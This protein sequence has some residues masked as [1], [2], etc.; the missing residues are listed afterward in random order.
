MQGPSG[1]TRQDH[2][3]RLRSSP[4]LLAEKFYGRCFVVL[5]IE[6]GA[7]LGDLQKV[8]DLVGIRTL[9]KSLLRGRSTYPVACTPSP[10]DTTSSFTQKN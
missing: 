1:E 7:E 3:S 8:V 10:K 2:S 5:H 4:A 6:D 9:R